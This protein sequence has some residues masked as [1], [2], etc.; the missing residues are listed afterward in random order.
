M[1]DTITDAI[2]RTA[3]G[4][5]SATVDGASATAQDIDKMIKAKQFLGA[6]AAASNNHLGLRF[7]K[8][9]SPRAG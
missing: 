9:E 6:E 4:P 7:F 8:L 3:K 2:E 1:A 5:A